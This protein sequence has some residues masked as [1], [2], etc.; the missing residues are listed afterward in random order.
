MPKPKPSSS[1]AVTDPKK[2]NRHERLKTA[3]RWAA[4]Q[5]TEKK[6]QA[7]R[8]HFGVD[9]CCAAKELTMAGVALTEKYASRWATRHERKALHKKRKS[10]HKVER[11]YV[12]PESD[13]TFYFIAGYTA[14]GFAYGITWEQA[15]EDGL[16][17]EG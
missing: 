8:E 13:E 10:A 9:K 1:N 15:E 5:K 6:I 12:E 7:Y 2:M 14:G 4:S 11:L 17:T 16:L 3:K